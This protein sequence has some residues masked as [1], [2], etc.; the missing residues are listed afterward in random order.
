MSRF[1]QGD[2]VIVFQDNMLRMPG[3]FSHYFDESQEKAVVNY[4]HSSQTFPTNQIYRFDPIDD[5][6]RDQWCA[7]EAPKIVEIIKQAMEAMFPGYNYTL[8][9]R[10]DFVELDGI[11]LIPHTIQQRSIGRVKEF[12]GWQLTDWKVYAATQWEP[13]DIVDQPV[14][15]HRSSFDAARALI[16][17][18]LANHVNRWFEATG[19]ARDYAALQ[20]LEQETT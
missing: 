19:E 4:S 15:E 14:S 10:E 16:N 2:S 7:E 13:E 5:E 8:E 1:K 12:P 17:Y 18:A 11:S 6:E 9:I 3:T 20:Q